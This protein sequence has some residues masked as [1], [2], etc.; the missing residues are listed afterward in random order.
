MLMTWQGSQCQNS[1]NLS[2]KYPNHVS[3]NRIYVNVCVKLRGWPRGIGSACWNMV[4]CETFFVA[5]AQCRC[6]RSVFAKW[7][8]IRHNGVGVRYFGFMNDVRA[9]RPIHWARKLEHPDTYIGECR[10]DCCVCV[11]HSN[12]EL[13]CAFVCDRQS[14]TSD[15]THRIFYRRM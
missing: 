1:R 2:R 10:I 14:A 15:T 8:D 5:S 12:I 13:I 11:L 7:Q 6:H 4:Y 3:L 9:F